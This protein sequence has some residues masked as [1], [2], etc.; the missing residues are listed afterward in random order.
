[1]NHREELEYILGKYHKDPDASLGNL[2][3]TTDRIMS[4]FAPRPID[5]EAKSGRSIICF[6]VENYDVQVGVFRFKGGWQIRDAYGDWYNAPHNPYFVSYIPLP[7]KLP[8][9]TEDKSKE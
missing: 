6:W 4:L 2:Y 8:V 3:E 1:M 5:G 7:D 9:V